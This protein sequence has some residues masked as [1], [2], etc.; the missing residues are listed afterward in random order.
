MTRPGHPDGRADQPA[1]ATRLP[2]AA[3]FAPLG[4]IEKKK[5]NKPSTRTLLRTCSRRR[6]H[7]RFYLRPSMALSPRRPHLRPNLLFLSLSLGREPNS[8]VPKEEELIT[9]KR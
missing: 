4:R 9:I 7:L 8:G 2:R 5:K 1:R 6:R 3:Q